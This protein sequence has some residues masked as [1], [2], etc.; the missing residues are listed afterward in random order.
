MVDACDKV[1]MV[2]PSINGGGLLRRMLPTLRFDPSR[3]VVLDQGSTDDTAEVCAESNVELVQ[4]S[5]PHT[6]TQAC[7]IG[8]SIARERGARYVCVSNND[9]VFRTDVIGAMLTEME[10]DDRLGIVAPSQIIVDETLGDQPLSY[11]VRWDLETVD[12]FHEVKPLEF[13]QRRLESDFCELTC[14]LVRLSV[15]DEIGFLDD[16][17][18]FYHED[19]DFGYRLRQ[20]GYSCAYLPTAQIEH[21]SSSTFNKDKL[22]LKAEY[23]AKNKQHFARK[24]LG[25]GLHQSRPS[26]RH[27][28]A[29]DAYCVRLHPFLKHYGLISPARPELVMSSPGAETQGYI[30]TAYEGT[31]LPPSWSQA[32]ERYQGVFTTSRDTCDL[33]Q[34]AGYRDAFVAPLG[35]ETDVFNPWGPSRRLF[36]EKTY[37]AILD[38][39]QTQALDLILK[40]WYLFSAD[41][42]HVKLVLFGLGL[43]D[44]LGR[45]PDS[46]YRWGNSDIACFAAER[47]VV[48]EVDSWPDDDDLAFMYRSVDFSIGVSSNEGRLATILESH[49]C[50]VPCI[51][52]DRGLSADFKFEGS[53]GFGGGPDA[54]LSTVTPKHPS[55]DD[56]LEA[57]VRSDRLSDAELGELSE[58]GLLRVRNGFTVRNSAMMVR[59]ALSQI[60]Q[61]DPEPTIEALRR[62]QN[63]ANAISVMRK[64][65]ST[66]LTRLGGIAARRLKTAGRLTEQF[67]AAWESKGFKSATEHTASELGYFLKA[68]K[69]RWMGMRRDLSRLGQRG[70]QTA[71]ALYHKR[72]QPVQGSTLL[73][74]YIDAQLGLGQSLR[75]LALALSRTN[76]PFAIY[77]FTVGVEERRGAPYM[78][79]RYDTRLA[80][81]VNVIE[82]T[83]DELPKVFRS[84]SSTRFDR[85]YNILRTYWELS[86]APESWRTKL[87]SINEI[88]APNAFVADSFRTVFDGPI[89]V[90][91]P[92]V[93]PPD[94]DG[95]PAEGDARAQFGLEAGRFYFFFSFDYYSF[96][97]RKNPLAVVR[98]FQKAFPDHAARVGLVVKSTGSADHHPEVKK[99]LVRMASFDDRIRIIDQSL[100]RGQML[101]LMKATDCYV[102][103]HRAE[104]FG[105]GMAEAMT[106]GKPVIGTNYSGNTEFVRP[107]T[108]YPIAFRLKRLSPHDYIYTEGQVWAEPDEMDCAAAML[109]VVS[110]PDEAKRRASAGKAFIQERFGVENVARLIDDRLGEILDGHGTITQA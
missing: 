41:R 59:N 15:I 87:A 64:G 72:Q 19:A 57:L 36:D 70:S 16:E 84:I 76:R 4:L 47:I 53:L 83:P 99:Q 23:I 79:E 7:N 10:R 92:C 32:S 39:S 94:I 34:A 17:Y 56:L 101:S 106:L 35:V 8:A 104:G 1:L 96:L 46:Q 82:V 12:F 88:W 71:T 85:S 62:R 49:A 63:S 103:L 75:G 33:F 48:H 55:A 100:S 50:G 91:P 2:I 58:R 102:S 80:H 105:L 44:S 93:I 65:Q 51:F 69:Q 21:F 20:S 14:A 5:Q 40:S 109:K 25:Y 60:Q 98:A 6:Y 67:G 52:A 97:Q 77:P 9:I 110:E 30:Y 108:A 27:A 45:A 89:T 43:L 28:D 29:W 61:R 11:R 22:A 73:V 90:I 86:R 3:V 66:A 95:L 38:R 68:S 78:A 24:N 13:E 26:L 37:L 18:G 81:A 74:G 107:D 54:G 42:P 31:A